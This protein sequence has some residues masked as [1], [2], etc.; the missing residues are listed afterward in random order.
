MLKIDQIYEVCVTKLIDEHHRAEPG[1]ITPVQTDV[2]T[3]GRNQFYCSIDGEG[4]Y[5]GEVL[6]EILEVG[7]IRR[8]KYRGDGILYVVRDESLTPHNA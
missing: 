3:I 4:Q 1:F 5:V 6:N 8:A 2:P 7:D